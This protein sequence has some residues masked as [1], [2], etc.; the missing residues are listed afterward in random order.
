MQGLPAAR[1]FDSSA[2]C[3]RFLLDH[4][5]PES[6][7]DIWLEQPNSRLV[8]L[9]RR[10][11]FLFRGEPGLF[12]E[13]KP[14][15]GRMDTWHPH[16]GARLSAE[17]R[18]I[19]PKLS[20]WVHRALTAPS[21][22]LSDFEA[23]PVLQHYGLP[24]IMLDLTGDPG[25]AMAFAIGSGSNGSGR[26][27]VMPTKLSPN[28]VS[29]VELR[30]HVWAVRAQRQHAFTIARLAPP[31]LD[32]KS[33][34][35]R[36]EL[37]VKWYEFPITEQDRELGRKRYQELINVRDD[38]TAALLRYHAIEYVETFGKVPHDLARWIVGKIPMV[39][40][41]YRDIELTADE[42]VVDHVAPAEVEFDEEVERDCTLRYLSRDYRDD[43]KERVR[44]WVRL[45]VG[46]AV[47]GPPTLHQT[48]SHPRTSA[49]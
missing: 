43:S 47:A 21:Y 49:A 33:P 7:S 5:D 48:F 32:L 22:K 2:R 11:R 20:D 30:D 45:E 31:I 41:L 34:R 4:Y 40:R 23:I 12:A 28:G 14:S 35:E 18:L 8:S 42:H 15:A 10:P 6:A 44:D 16:N 24:T 9:H 46:G 37:G 39:P 36:E 19:F 1:R 13:T 25:V 29:I 38:P 17:A 27:A 3:L 26:I